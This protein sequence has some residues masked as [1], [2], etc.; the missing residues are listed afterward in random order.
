M[1][2]IMDKLDTIIGRQNVETSSGIF[3][4]GVLAA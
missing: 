3:P 2:M 4:G 1:L